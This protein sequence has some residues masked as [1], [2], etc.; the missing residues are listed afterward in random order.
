M[1]RGLGWLGAFASAAGAAA[2]VA[3]FVPG[4]RVTLTWLVP[5]LVIAVIGF[6]AA[7]TVAVQG[8]CSG[9]PPPAGR[10]READARL[11][12]DPARTRRVRS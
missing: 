10:E 9:P 3:S 6:C 12:V 11:A 4:V 1:R 2:H 7:I 5:F 8:C